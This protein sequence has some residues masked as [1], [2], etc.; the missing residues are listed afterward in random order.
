MRIKMKRNFLLKIIILLSAQVSYASKPDAEYQEVSHQI[1]Y[2]SELAEQAR[3]I[4]QNRQ[5]KEHQLNPQ[6]I[7]A[8]QQN[9]LIS[10]LLNNAAKQP[11]L[12]ID[13]EKDQVINEY[14]YLTYLYCMEPN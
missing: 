7:E 4:M 1:Q 5:Y 6:I 8:V 9:S 2:C 13:A 3:Q 11:I 12:E 10:A 14:K